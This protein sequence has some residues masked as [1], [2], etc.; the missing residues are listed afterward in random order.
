MVVAAAISFGIRS[1]AE[2]AAA[3]SSGL[4]DALFAT[5]V[6]AHA[7]DKLGLV[8]QLVGDWA[9]V[10]TNHLPD[11][12]L[13]TLNGEW[14]F[15]WILGGAAIQD[16]WMVPTQAERDSGKPL[17]AYGTTLRFYDAKRDAMRV[18]WASASYRNF[19]LFTARDSANE[20]V[21]D[22]ENV[23]P[24]MRWIFSDVTRDRFRWRAVASKDGWKTSDIQQEMTAMRV[25]NG[26]GL[27]RALLADAPAP[28]FERENHLF[29]QFVGDWA[30]RYEGFRPDGAIVETTGALNVGWVLGGRVVQ[31]VWSFRGST[32]GQSSAGTTLR[33]YDPRLDAWH[34]IWFYPAG[35]VIETFIA[36]QK[37]D[38]IVLDGSSPTGQPQQW[39]FSKITPSSFDWREIVSADER[40][41]WHVT[42]H[43]WIE[44]RPAKQTQSSR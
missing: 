2:P 31:D 30:I 15:G 3:P 16:V 21:M 37:N 27:R 44:R 17:V 14:H 34:S 22:A 41:S 38:E 39:I 12:T 19:T 24:P 5:A 11:G 28:G 43:M 42:E 9:V 1:T 32:A 35:N 23:Q 18:V 6:D 10:V 4:A 36:R 8:R 13:Q 29:G 20:I 25:A 26:V 33:L 40:A 7:S